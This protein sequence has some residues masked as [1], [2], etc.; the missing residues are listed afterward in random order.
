MNS[1]LLIQFMLNKLLIWEWEWAMKKKYVKRQSMSLWQI[2][3][4]E[5]REL[6]V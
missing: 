3:H 5:G 1:N 2:A 6:K 4:W